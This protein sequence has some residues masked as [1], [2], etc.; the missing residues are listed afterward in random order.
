VIFHDH[1]ND[2]EISAM[3][4]CCRKTTKHHKRK[5]FDLTVPASSS[6]YQRLEQTRVS[7]FTKS[8]EVP[9]TV[10][11]TNLE[12]RVMICCPRV[13]MKVHNPLP[14]NLD[15]TCSKAASIL[16]HF[17]KGTNEL[18]QKLIP[19]NVL[20]QAAGVAIITMVKAGCLWSGRAGSGI[21][22]S[23]LDDGTWSAPSAIMAVG[24]GFGAQLGAQ[25]TDVVFILNNRK[26]VQ[27]FSTGNFTIGGNISVAA[28]PTGRST[29]AGGCN[30]PL[31]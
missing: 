27:A 25:I 29:E 23:R 24:C 7:K 20:K 22:V 4:I 15:I 14:E 21:V 1:V 26:A 11:I 28:G 5:Y 12:P 9:S 13:E 10:E 17:I 31:T 18:D 3:V 16:E 2:S 30:C 6:A 19:Q 8:M